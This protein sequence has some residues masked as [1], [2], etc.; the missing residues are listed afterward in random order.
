MVTPVDSWN[1]QLW[2]KKTSKYPDSDWISWHRSDKRRYI[3]WRKDWFI[4]FRLSEVTKD[5]SSLS[6]FLNI[7]N[8]TYDC[9]L[10]KR[11]FLKFEDKF[12]ECSIL[13]NEVSIGEMQIVNCWYRE[14]YKEPEISTLKC[15]I[16]YLQWFYT[17]EVFSING[18]VTYGSI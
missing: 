15:R 9:T 2:N 6:K 11:I 18:A 8:K 5:V 10:F 12:Y 7:Q 4:L 3:S 13:L 14:C 17:K 16:L 1:Q